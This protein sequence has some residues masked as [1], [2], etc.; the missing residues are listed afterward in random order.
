VGIARPARRIKMERRVVVE[1]T[2]TPFNALVDA[3]AL[4]ELLN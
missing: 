2:W 1:T 3:P 4:R